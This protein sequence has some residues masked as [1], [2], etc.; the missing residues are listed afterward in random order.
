MT[1]SAKINSGKILIFF[2]EK[3]LFKIFDTK[4]FIIFALNQLKNH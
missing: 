3:K 2:A 4:I 1:H